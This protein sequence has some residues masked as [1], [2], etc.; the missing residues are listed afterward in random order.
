ME[1]FTSMANIVT[2]ICREVAKKNYHLVL[3]KQGT[4][5]YNKHINKRKV[6]VM[7]KN[8]RISDFLKK[9]NKELWELAETLSPNDFLILAEG[10]DKIANLVKEVADAVSPL[11]ED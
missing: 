10:I 1:D 6:S 3:D 8:R 4:K 9:Y 2:D 7:E 11:S 5:W